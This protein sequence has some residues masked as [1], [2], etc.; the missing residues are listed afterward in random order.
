MAIVLRRMTR[1]AAGAILAGGRPVDVHVA[2]DY[3]T[4]FSVGVAQCVGADRQFGPFFLHRSEDD[5]VVG[6]I[7]GA[8]IDETGT[9]EIGY[10]VV[11]SQWNRGYATA[12]VEALVSKARK[13][14]QVR[15]IVAHT[16]LERPQSGRVLEK[17]GFALVQEMDEVDE[18]RN[19]MRVKEWVLAI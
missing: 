11:V 16:P 12:A 13:A 2:D 9:V 14:P 6:E 7:G 4:E 17:A 15:R 19:V 18:A 1:E 10:A 8:F 3:P 5:L